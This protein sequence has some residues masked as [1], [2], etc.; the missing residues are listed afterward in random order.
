LSLERFVSMQIKESLF[1]QAMQILTSDVLLILEVGDA[2][3]NQM[4][5]AT[6]LGEANG[7]EIKQAGV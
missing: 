7:H 3:E 1:A 5:V 4:G 6:R 2:L